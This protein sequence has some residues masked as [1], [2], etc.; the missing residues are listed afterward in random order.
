MNRKLG[1]P[2]FGTHMAPLITSVM[3]TDGP[4]FEMGCGDYSTPILHAICEKQQRKL[5][6]TDTSNEWLNLF[7]D[8]TSTYHKFEYV[9]VYEDD[10]EKNPKPELWDKVGNQ[11]W[12]VV[13]IDHRPGER[14]KDDIKRFQNSADIVVVH[15]TETE[16]YRYE[17]VFNLFKY[18][19]DYKRYSTYTTI[20]SN[21]IDVSKLFT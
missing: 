9:P 18:R 8:L 20:V 21:K 15:D 13:F 5:L 2:N 1:N 16:S 17:S 6:S 12:G 4:I 10:W 3:N 19:Y 11:N 7:I 14:R